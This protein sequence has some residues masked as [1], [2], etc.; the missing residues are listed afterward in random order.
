MHPLDFSCS[1]FY[2]IP[3]A[4]S[5]YLFVL[6]FTTRPIASC[7]I[8]CLRTDPRARWQREMSGKPASALYKWQSGVA[9]IYKQ[10][11][12][13]SEG[14][15]GRVWAPPVTA[16]IGDELEA[17]RGA[18]RD[19][20]ARVADLP[21]SERTCSSLFFFLHPACDWRLARTS[22]PTRVHLGAAC[23]PRS[24][25]LRRPPLP[26]SHEPPSFVVSTSSSPLFARVSRHCLA[27]ATI[28][29]FSTAC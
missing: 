2:F 7:Q 6:L 28:A 18:E 16:E 5:N 26:V 1:P 29:T 20:R 13:L 10:D 9:C 11:D 15:R 8:E 4:A 12:K 14:K 23:D 22:S 25:P 27:D 17:R 21:W 24:P 19:A 3:V